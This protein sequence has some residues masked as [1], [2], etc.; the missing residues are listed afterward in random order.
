MED[1]RQL[2]REE[3]F[4]EMTEVIKTE[5]LWKTQDEGFIGAL[6]WML[7][8]INRLKARD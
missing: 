6:D 5:K 1:E 2:G 8:E 3:A 7:L 4:A